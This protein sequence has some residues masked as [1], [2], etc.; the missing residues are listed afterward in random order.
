MT[1]W[2]S[3]GLRGGENGTASAD[4]TL[5][6][7]S[8][9]Y[10]QWERCDCDRR[11]RLRAIRLVSQFR[12]SGVQIRSVAPREFWERACVAFFQEGIDANRNSLLCNR[13]ACSAELNLPPSIGGNDSG[14]CGSYTMSMLRLTRS[15]MVHF[16]SG[17]ARTAQPPQCEKILALHCSASSIFSVRRRLFFPVLRSQSCRR[18]VRNVG[19]AKRFPRIVESAVCFPSIRHFHRRGS[20]RSR[21]QPANGLRLAHVEI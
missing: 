18:P 6:R 12:V 1:V 19:I 10:L 20:I 11:D 9:I 4:C 2:I 5:N 17:R 7:S 13:D 21:V 14:V 8:A 3:S 16:V 15:Y